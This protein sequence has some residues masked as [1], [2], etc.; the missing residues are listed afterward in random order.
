MENKLVGARLVE[1]GVWCDHKGRKIFVVIKRL[2]IVIE[3]VVTQI[4]TPDQMT[5]IYTVY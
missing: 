1:E 2:C 3:V 5:K 4:Y